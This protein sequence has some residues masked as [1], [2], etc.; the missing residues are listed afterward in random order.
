MER[1]NLAFPCSLPISY[2]IGSIDPRFGISTST[3]EK[4]LTLA[5]KLWNSA[6]GRDLIL[7]DQRNGIIT[8]NLAYDSRQEM[9]QR[10]KRIGVTISNDK[11]SYDQ[12]KAKY[13]AVYG[14][15]LSKK[16][17]FES[18]VSSF[19]V[20]RDA[21]QKQVEYWNSRGGA[22]K[23]EYQKL[24]QEQQSLETRSRDLQ[25]LQNSVN[26][27]A[28][29]VNDLAQALNQLIAE[30]N[31]NV[32]KY[33]TTGQENGSSFEQGLYE[34]E[35]GVETI[36]IFEYE[37]NALLIRVLAH[38]L[39]HALGLDHVEDENAIMYYLN[40]GDEIALTASDKAELKAVC[41]L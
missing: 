13:D 4:D 33:N 1:D 17:A 39:G 12:L 15:F 7:E 24:Q 31:L 10:L 6:S 20:A 9:T 32:Q 37:N 18:A 23:N 40:R 25:A 21:Y 41:R 38:E 30:L 14:Q 19:N 2:R 16:Q 8:V 28:E 27:L 35:L 3:L 5:S 36:T 26:A 34:R 22:P 11:A 29:N